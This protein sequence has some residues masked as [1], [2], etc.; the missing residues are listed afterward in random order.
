MTFFLAPR[1]HAKSWVDRYVSTPA[2]RLLLALHVSPNALTLLGLGIVAGA[3]YLLAR[4]ELLI[5]GIVML[6]GAALDMLDGA[7]A[8]LGRQSSQFGALLDSLADRL[9]EAAVFFG[10]LFF[11]YDQA[12]TLGVL[13]SFGALVASFTVSYVRARAEGLG[14]PADVGFM[15]RP[16]RV[17]LL[18][19]GLL[20]G[21]P[22]YSLGAIIGL[23]L[24]TVAQRIVHTA[25]H[26]TND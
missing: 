2:A 24:L 10:L 25:R 16:E 21:Y 22:L 1:L 6:A 15:G 4:G 26:S 8:R 11:Y 9:G 14:I 3:A 20:A 13:L 23:A 19:G 18:G 12:H 7:V 5:G 17:V